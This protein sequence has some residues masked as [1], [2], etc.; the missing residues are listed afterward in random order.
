MLADAYATSA[1]ALGSAKAEQ[2]VKS[3]GL[4]ALF[5]LADSTV[6]THNFPLSDK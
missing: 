5:V 2:M 4:G 3:L 6:W 1:M